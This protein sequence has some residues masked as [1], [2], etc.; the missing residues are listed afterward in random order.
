[1]DDDCLLAIVD[2]FEASEKLNNAKHLCSEHDQLTECRHARE[3]DLK[4]SDAHLKMLTACEV[5]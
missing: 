2:Y 4:L 1:M 3:L 5:G